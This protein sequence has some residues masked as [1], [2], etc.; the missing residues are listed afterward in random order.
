MRLKIDDPDYPLGVKGKDFL[1][2]VYLEMIS[3]LTIP[4]NLLDLWERA[5]ETLGHGEHF[6]KVTD[7]VNARL[8]TIKLNKKGDNNNA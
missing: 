1:V 5:R 4:R 6:D 8:I 7:A 2:M 3:D